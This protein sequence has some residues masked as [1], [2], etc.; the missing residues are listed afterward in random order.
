MF[1]RRASFQRG[2]RVFN[3]LLV[4]IDEGPQVLRYTDGAIDM[5]ADLARR[6]RKLGISVVVLATDTT[7]ND[8]K[9]SALQKSE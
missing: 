4:L 2:T 7:L 8:A 6:G 1:Q 9:R 3:P 5:V